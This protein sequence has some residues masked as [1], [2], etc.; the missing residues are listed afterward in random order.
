VRVLA[1]VLLLPLVI[2]AGCSAANHPT[3]LET[4]PAAHTDCYAGTS[5]G[6]GQGSHTIARRTVDPV[7]KTI[8][9]D[10]SHDNAGPHGARSFHVV[11]TVDGDHF[12]MKET[13][14]A[15]A[16]TGSLVGQPWQW[17]SWS[18]VS[19]IAGTAIT[20]ESHDELTSY[21]M[22]AEKQIKQDGKVIA[23]T[24]DDLRAFECAQWDDAK[25]ALLTPV[26]D[27]PR[28]EQACRNFATLKF[29]QHADDEISALP[30]AD[31]AAARAA[32]ADELATKLA[33]GL[34]TCVSAC[35]AANNPEQTACW[36]DATTV[37]QL[38]KCDA[39]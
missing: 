31:Q 13:A 2:A 24:V 15:F 36:G 11:M 26:A 20:V 10:V 6:M 28:C 12:T 35:F 27:K 37:E 32:K 23:T 18:S 9:E 33:A 7:A 25:T 16:G 5:T 8:T 1:L 3:P 17:T 30:Q 19:Q 22:K 29:W 4:A 14:G 34:D 39:S 38:A 21:G